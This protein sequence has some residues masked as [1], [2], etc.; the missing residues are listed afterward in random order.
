MGMEIVII[1]QSEMHSQI[2]LQDFK[3]LVLQSDYHDYL[4]TKPIPEIGLE[5]NEVTKAT[6]AYMLKR[7]K[8]VHASDITRSKELPEKQKEVVASIL[9]RLANSKGSF[10]FEA[11][12]RGLNTPLY[13]QEEKYKEITEKGIRLD[14][15]SKEQ[16]QGMPFYVKSYDYTYG[17]KSGAFTEEFIKGEKARHG[18]LFDMYYGAKPFA[19]DISWFVPEDFTT[20]EQATE[21]F[22]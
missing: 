20:S 13:E 5:R 6:V 1:G 7:V 15:M 3:K 17:L 12:H 14:K 4:I 16:Q 10:V 19:S 22:G 21:F 2:H 8:H 11:P 18:I 9:S